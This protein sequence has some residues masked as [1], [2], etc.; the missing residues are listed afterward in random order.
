[1]LCFKKINNKF[2]E[3]EDG[4]GVSILCLFFRMLHAS[5]KYFARFF[6][7]K[8][9][10]SNCFFQNANYE[11]FTRLFQ[12]K[13]F[14]FP[15]LLVLE[16]WCYIQVFFVDLIPRTRK[17]DSLKS[18]QICSFFFSSTLGQFVFVGDLP[19]QIF[20]WNFFH[21]F[22]RRHFLLS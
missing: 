2:D 11:I 16:F 1:M 3:W 13:E 12:L 15:E 21:F 7:A 10:S 18:G 9:I 17:K 20:T 22:R 5:C 19:A 6:F 14:L 4:R 8:K